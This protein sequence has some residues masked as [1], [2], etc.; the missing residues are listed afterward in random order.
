MAQVWLDLELA[1][2]DNPKVLE[3]ACIITNAELE[4]ADPPLSAHHTES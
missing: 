4:G 3:A 2:L 1:S